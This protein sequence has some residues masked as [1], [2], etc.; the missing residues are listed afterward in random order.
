[1]DYE[2]RNTRLLS[3]FLVLVSICALKGGRS[4]EVI[5]CKETERQALLKF[6]KGLV[7]EYDVLSSWGSEE[8]KRE[9][10]KWRGVGC[11]NKTG[12]VISLHLTEEILDRWHALGGNLSDALV[13]LRHLISLDLSNN[14]FSDNEIPEF[15]GSLD[16]L[17]YLN[18]SYCSLEGKVPGQLGNLTNLRVL[19]LGNNYGG[20]MI[21]NL[22]WISNLSSLFHL[23]LRSSSF[24]EGLKTVVF[25]KILIIKSLKELYLGGCRFP[26]DTSSVDAYVN[27]TFASLSVLDLSGLSLTSLA[28][29]WLF[30]IST[31]LLSFD[32]S[33]NEFDGS[34]PDGF[35]QKLVSL[36]NL[37]LSDNKFEGGIP[38]SFWNLKGLK[39]LHLS[40]NN[41]TGSLPDF[42]GTMVP[43]E[44]LDLSYNRI[45]GSVPE[46]FWKASK[47]EV[48][49]ATYNSLEGTISESHLSKLHNLKKLDLNYNSLVFNLTPDWDPPFQL[50]FLKLASCKVGPRFPTWVRTQSKV[51]QLD[52]SGANIS[53]ELPEWFWDSL[54]RLEF[55][56]LSHNQISGRLPDLSS[57]LSGH[58]LLDLSFNEFAGL[59]PSFHPNTTC[60][61]LSNN[62]FFGSISFLCK[63]KYDVLGLLD[64][65]NNQ[66][67]GQI[68]DCWEN[69]AVDILDLSN[70]NFSGEIPDTLGSA[71]PMTLHLF[72][73][74]LSGELPSSLKNSGSLEVLDVGS[75]KLT[76][77]IPAW[78]G[79]NLASLVILNIRGNNFFGSIPPE[80]CYLTQIQILD[81]SRNNL[82]GRIPLHCFKNFTIFVQKSSKTP[83]GE[84]GT[85]YSYP[86]VYNVVDKVVVQWKGR[87]FEYST[88]L[89][90]LTLIDLSSNRIEGN[91]PKEIF[92]MEGLV[93]LNL[94]RNHL[95]G[96][97]DP[98]IHQ[99]ESLECL[100]VSRN[101]LS[102]E[103]PKGL[104]TLPFL[105]FLD[106]SNNNFSGK[107]P[108]GTQLQGFN[109]SLYAGNIGLCGPP[110][111]MCPE[112][113]PDPLSGHNSEE[114]D[115]DAFMN[116]S[117]LKEFYIT[118]VLGFIVGFW[119]IIGTLLLCKPCA[120]FSFF[121]RIIC[122]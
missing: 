47:L 55:L 34:I 65:S 18:L 118:I 6:K 7:D 19:D 85:S 32:L 107:I 93:S 58:P 49:Y 116:Q 94:S 64:F 50:E 48:L 81:L 41:L 99:M 113:Y 103:I 110:L 89:Y 2:K 51:S 100:D 84:L 43:L 16:K 87:V 26:N 30:N 3:A 53:D 52:L 24:T 72:N 22:D 4:A 37:D 92:Q 5:R 112:D 104:G 115:D 12:H 8:N 111:P 27:S 38:K 28:F 82:S 33:S 97:I 76:G 79:T 101:Q 29:H 13:D 71:L 74:S 68:P 20:L 63:S 98:A 56:N 117:F 69:T 114:N 70:N 120:Y 105:A 1:M 9:C 77:N 91:I 80:L 102:G 75:N 60:L 42:V 25:Q 21:Q 11:S 109:A 108:S 10:C 122:T 14:D 17:R 36:E 119:G 62:N 96:N 15:M 54:P 23:D 44:I 83:Y 61:Y 121:D 45:T 73:N 40:S 88:T 57:K 106:L 35:G 95:K 31:S 86:I 78:I 90:L 59:I 46:S 39:K 67:S 66:L